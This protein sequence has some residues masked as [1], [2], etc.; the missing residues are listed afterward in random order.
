MA[1]FERAL[2]TLLFEILTGKTGNIGKTTFIPEKPAFDWDKKDLQPLIRSTPEA[3]GVS[4][5]LIYNL[6]SELGAAKK[7][8]L[9]HFLVI[10]HGKIISE[11]SFSPYRKGEWHTTYSMSKTFTGM[12]IGLLI[13]D[14]K[15][16]LT[17]KVTDIVGNFANIWQMLK[18]REL[19]VENLLTMTSGVGFNESGA[20]AGDDWIK[21][22]L[23]SALN[24]QPGRTFSYNSMN[25]Y[26]L[27]AIVTRLSGKS[28]QEFL[29]ERIFDK[30]GIVQSFWETSPE[31]VTKGGWGMFIR[32]EDAARLGLLYLNK[33][34]WKGEQ[35][36]SEDFVTRATSKQVEN[37]YFGYGYQL[38]R[39]RR[40]GSFVFNGMMG[41]DVHVY[42]DLDMIIVNFAGDP[43]VF[44]TGQV[45]KILDKYMTCLT[46]SDIA[47]PDNPVGFANLLKL[48]KELESGAFNNKSLIA[49]GWGK[50]DNLR[51]RVSSWNKPHPLKH[52][53]FVWLNGR[54]YVLADKSL[55][56][57]PLLLQ[58]LHNNFT[59]GIGEVG[60]VYENHTL[61]IKLKEGE[62]VHKL[63]IGF[64][65]PAYSVINLK[66]DPYN[67]A[68]KGEYTENEEHENVLKLELSFTEEAAKR[69]IKI[70]FINDEI[71]F[72]MSETPGQEFIKKGMEVSMNQIMNSNFILKTALGSGADTIIKDS[73]VRKISPS[74]TGSI[75]K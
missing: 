69:I 11:T 41:Q 60:F 38:W 37:D 20:L 33:G 31:G 39:G 43:V 17:D 7:I 5:E 2:A 32:P 8:D 23:S 25:S 45:D 59:D 62:E 21:G 42:P 52:D 75:K 27:S 56:V 53:F 46:L 13:D 65:K 29:Q 71:L 50:R 18:L 63:K 47:L 64:H 70:H 9:H 1:N 54:E 57:F 26:I 66:G 40:E 15:L 28:M 68:V 74:T 4:S 48:S 36:I 67:V 30:L 16:K 19:T 49:G 35:I 73:V 10:R 6:L 14:G 24:E 58:L 55:G 3:E 61:Y 12:A 44:Q 51:T 22:F 34:K 72:E